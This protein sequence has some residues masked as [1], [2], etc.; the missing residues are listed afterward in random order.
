MKDIKIDLV[1]LWVDDKDEEW[2]KKRHYWANKLGV[3]CSEEN[4]D[5]RYS[6]NDE[7]KYSLRSAEMYAPWI[8]KIFIVTDGQVPE[9]LDTN[10]PKIKIVNHKD[11]MPEDC[12]PCFNS[13]ALETCIDNIPDLSE[14]F[15]Y[16]NDDMF[17]ASPVK[18][19]DF[20]TDDEK[21]IVHLRKRSWDS[22][23]NIHMQ[24]ILYTTKLFKQKYD[25][26]NILENTEPSHC[27]DAYRRSYIKAC[28]KHFEKEFRSTVKKTFRAE[29]AVQRI[30]ISY[31]MLVN[32]LAD[33]VLDPEVVDQDFQEHV[34]NLYL[35]LD[36][37]QYMRSKIESLTPKLLCINDSTYVCDT[38]RKN[39]KYLLYDLFNIR[40]PWEK[41]Y[42]SYIEPVFE[43][44]YYTIV[45]SFNNDYC[46]YFA[47]ALQS[48]IDNACAD[49]K[50]DIIVFCAD[51]EEK[52]KNLLYKILPPNFSLRFFD[53][54]NYLNNQFSNLKLK[55]MN[56]WSIEIYYRIFIP[57]VMPSYKKVLYL[58]SDTVVNCK[59]SELFEIDFE[60]NEILAVRDTTPQVFNL[61]RNRERFEYVTNCLKLKNEKNYFN[62]GMIMFNLKNISKSNYRSRVL[63]AF[64]IENLLYPDQDILNVMFEDSVKLIS[65]KWNFCCGDV[66]W[67]RNFLNLLSGEY[68]QDFKAAMKNPKIIHYTSPRKPWNYTLEI[69]FDIFWQYARKSPFYEEILYKMNRDA[70]FQIIVESA[71]YTN[72][73]LKIQDT[74]RIVFWGASIFLE[75]FINR[76]D[77]INDNIIGIIDKNPNKKGKFI[78]E[79]EIFSPEDLD[80]L[81][82]DEIIITIVNSAR[83]R[84]IEIMDYLH[85]H[86]KKEIVVTTI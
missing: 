68:L 13:N 6:N 71:K 43:S 54:L 36:P 86:H 16:A 75:D 49:K 82:P 32:D 65:S 50:Y 81:D 34:D 61:E 56:S 45:F 78:R 67:D 21:P 53:M 80:K 72:L 70:A 42:N 77:I 46:K 37:I 26:N 83:E 17:F 20:F 19:E 69:N 24:N 63:D 33:L 48:L 12:L 76:Y 66:V 22:A 85:S 84:Q 52:N 11:I 79:Y 28:K 64:N 23:S 38:D 44:D 1:Y 18:P 59:I 39:L 30:I 40:Q 31:Y 4:N 29:D 55:T 2:Q 62:S 35:K 15:L 9:W 51:I 41:V 5:C 74:R 47:V 27:I 60:G 25:F 3:A 58:D 57:L 73:Y 14:Y 8:N 7:L 10:H